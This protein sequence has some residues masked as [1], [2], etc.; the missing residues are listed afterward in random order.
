MSRYSEE[1]LD[2]IL[3]KEIKVDIIGGVEGPCLSVNDYRVAGPK[4]WGGGKITR[5]WTV[6]I[7]DLIGGLPELKALLQDGEGK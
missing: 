2:K 7:K 6:T 1:E 5:S 4:P 3:N